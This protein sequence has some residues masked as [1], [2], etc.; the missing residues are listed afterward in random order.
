VLLQQQRAHSLA[1]LNRKRALRAIDARKVV[2]FVKAR[3]HERASRDGRRRRLRGG[4]GG[5]G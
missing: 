4:G 3:V 1:Q 2:Q 5:G